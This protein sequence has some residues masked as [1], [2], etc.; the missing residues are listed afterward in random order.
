MLLLNISGQ[1]L[2]IKLNLTINTRAYLG[3]SIYLFLSLHHLDSKY[4]EGEIMKRKN[5][6]MVVEYIDKHV[7]KIIEIL[8]REKFKKW[9]EEVSKTSRCMKPSLGI[10]IGTRRGLGVFPWEKYNE[11]GVKNEYN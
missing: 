3:S 4:H 9:S 6:F 1:T 5:C 2:T 8:D 11:Q 10:Y 7:Y